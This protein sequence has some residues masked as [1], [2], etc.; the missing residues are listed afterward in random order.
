VLP[1]DRGVPLVLAWRRA[2]RHGLG[3]H[4]G[5]AARPFNANEILVSLMLVYVAQQLLNY[6]SSARGRT[7]R[8]STSRRP[9]PST[10]P[11][12]CR[13]LMT[14]RGCT[15]ACSSRWRWW[16]WLGVPVP[17]L[18]RLPA[19]GGRPGAGG[20]ALC[21]LFVARALWTALLHLRR[22]GRAGRRLE[23]AGP[24][25]QLT[26]HVS[27]GYGFAAIIVAFVG[28]LHPVGMSSRLLL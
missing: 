11:P 4:R 10:P 27:T 7:R 3:G 2:R 21:R 17:H 18:P 14:A 1:L 13:N 12:G 8:A 24:L 19:A 9:R 25:G 15:S 22:P 20:G 23:A 16:R 5:L 6:W 26:P 28:R